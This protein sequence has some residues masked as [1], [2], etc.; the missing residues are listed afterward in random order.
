MSY[1]SALVVLA[2]I[3]TAAPRL[4]AQQGTPPVQPK[5]Q[6]TPLPPAIELPG[7]A[8]VPQDVPNRPLTGA[9]AVAI[10][11]HHQPSV[12]VAIAGVAGA[13]A[14]TQET[15]AALKPNANVSESWT[16]VHTNVPIVATFGSPGASVS[17]YVFTSAV[18]QLIY[19]FNH[20][21]DLVRQSL[22]EERLFGATLT[23]TQADLVLQ[24]KQDFYSYLQ[25]VRLIQVNEENVK[26]QQAHLALAQ[27]RLNSGL[28][29]PL[30][31]VRAETAVS[32]AI[33]N[34]STARNNAAQARVSLALLMGI[35]PR[36]PI[37][38]AESPEPPVLPVDVKLLT[39][40]ALSQRPEVTQAQANIDASVY[41]L[42][43]ARTT[44][45][46]IFSGAA[47]WTQRGTE[48]LGDQQIVTVGVGVTWN[49]FDGGFTAGRVKEA[50]ANLQ[51]AQDQMTSTQL[52]VMSDVAQ[53]YLNLRTAEQSVATAD[54]E[55]VNARESLRLARGRY[56]AGFGTF[57][58]VLDAQTALDTAET[59]RVNAVSA[60]DLARAALSHAAGN[61]LPGL[62]PPG[63]ASPKPK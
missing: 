35:D 30:D 12:D 14:R 11:L 33:L 32:E 22:A 15:A 57:L 47:G 53:A 7:P 20:T 16:G 1:R 5:V 55:I 62:R 44:N 8:S 28:G 39:Q 34:L 29:L 56:E 4:L 40:K 58:D 18:R 43:A 25:D 45:A 26:N 31:V 6:E 27:A 61:D 24:V 60:I 51:A 9:E 2:C 23:K 42:R 38:A 54:A 59:N 41:G 50:Q 10:A 21:R 46:P 37:V 13:Q 36:T 63:I 19:D 49:P 3:A 48:L 52:S 17:G